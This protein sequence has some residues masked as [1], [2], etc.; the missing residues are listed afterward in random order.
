M[1]QAIY[2]SNQFDFAKVTRVGAMTMIGSALMMC[3]SIL[4][5]FPLAENFTI[6]QQAVAHIGTIVFAGLFKVGYVTYIVGRKER[7]LEI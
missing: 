6:I 2:P 4:V 5:S 1:T 3:I 7:D